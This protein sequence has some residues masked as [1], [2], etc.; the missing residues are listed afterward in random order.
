MFNEEMPQ[1]ACVGN[2]TGST[3]MDGWVAAV[4]KA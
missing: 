4:L 3:A 2:R 1:L